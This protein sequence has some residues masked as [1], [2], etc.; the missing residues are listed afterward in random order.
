LINSEKIIRLCAE[1]EKWE[2][3]MKTVT[4]RDNYAVFRECELNLGFLY[5]QLMLLCEEHNITKIENGL[6]YL[7]NVR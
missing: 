1:I 2:D 6:I 5:N 4:V 3:R 7:T